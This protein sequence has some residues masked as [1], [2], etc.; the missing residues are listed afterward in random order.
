MAELRLLE[1]PLEDGIFLEEPPHIFGLDLI[2][3]VK[4]AE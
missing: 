4:V 2:D 3:P 1:P